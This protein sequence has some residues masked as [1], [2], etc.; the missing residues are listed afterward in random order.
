MD[1][2][3]Q[4]TVRA[5]IYNKR[6]IQYQMQDNMKYI[7]WLGIFVYDYPQQHLQKIY[8]DKILKT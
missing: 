6:F 5:I 7:S 1:E 4:F 3:C 8:L 2:Y